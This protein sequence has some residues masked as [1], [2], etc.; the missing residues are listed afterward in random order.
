MATGSAGAQA[1]RIAADGGLRFDS[2][3]IAW[4]SAMV[5]AICFAVVSAGMLI[6]A[7]SRAEEERDRLLRETADLKLAADRAEA[8]LS[9]DDQRVVIWSGGSDTPTVMGSLPEGSGA[10]RGSLAFLAFG[11][12]LDAASS[13]AL[14]DRIHALRRTGEIFSEILKTGAGTHVEAS[15][16]ISGSLC[17]VRFRNLSRERLQYV[18]LLDRHERQ[19]REVDTLHGLLEAL[20]MPVWARDKAG[21]LTFA[22]RAYARAVEA[23]DPVQAVTSQLELLDASARQQVAESREAGPVFAKRLS[24]V[25]AGTRRVFDVVDAS[26]GEASAGIATDVSELEKVQSELRRTIQNHARTLDQL[27]TAV[28]IF[29]ADRRLQF[30]NAA[31]G[32]LFGLDTAFLESGPE[33]GAVLDQL[34]TLRKLPEEADYRSWKGDMLGS[35][36]AMETRENWWHLPGGQTLRVIANPHPQGGVTYVYE[37]VTEQLGLESRYNALIRVQG[38]TLDHLSEGVAVFG[39]DGRLRLFNPAFVSL[40]RL[41]AGELRRKPHIND[42]VARCRLIHDDPIAWDQVRM[43]VA[44][45]ADT[46]TRV[47]GRLEGRGGVVDFGTVPLPDGATLVTFV[48]VTD[49]VNVERALLEKNEALEAADQLKNAFIQHVSYE[50][51]SPLTNIIGFAQLLADDNAGPL[52]GKQ[53][54][55]TGYIMDSSAALLAII[56][57]ILDLATVDAGIMELD[58][59]EVDI[60]ATAE[61]AIAGLRDRLAEARITLLNSVPADIGGFVADEKRVRQIL[62]NLLSNA[63]AFTPDGGSVE[64]GCR[65]EGEDVI[66]EVRDHGRGIPEEYLDAVFERFE[67]RSTGARRRGAGLGLSIVKSFVELHGGGVEIASREG[68]GTIVR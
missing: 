6:R 49:T 47:G 62:F 61:A 38:E 20:Q 64:I 36:Q 8:V 52:N 57:D 66:F 41:D 9:T 27:A 54:E 33:D 25:V 17:F 15:G 45:L 53:R 43:A 58:L 28:A 51:R 63:I 3:E 10:P 42:V 65:R 59:S 67:T 5:G 2:M 55:Y 35:Y 4:F 7:R 39:S 50:L 24:V 31:Y 14:D 30:Y 32:S 46:R 40:W 18:E 19:T 21:R 26:N 29:G 23:P 34:R 37:N 48:N 68:E 60:A 44:G 12:W 11:Q 16:R 1:V 56:N 22:N 13:K